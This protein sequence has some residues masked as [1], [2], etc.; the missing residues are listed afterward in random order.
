VSKRFSLSMLALTIGLAG[1]GSII[2]HPEQAV[3]ER[4]KMA[5][6]LSD[7]GLGDQSFSD[8]AMSGMS[9][10]REKEDWFI[11]Y[12][13]L[14]E[15]KSYETAFATLAK[16]HPTVVVGLGFMGQADL[17]KV[18]KQYPKQ[19]FA[20]IDAVSELPNV[21]SVTFKEDEG[22]YLAGAAA[23]IQSNNETIGFI[24]GMKSPLIE[25]FEKGYR[26]GATAINPDIR[27][28]VD[29]A[30][31]FA[32]PDKGR[33]LANAQ[34]KKEADVLYAAAGLTGSGV[35]EA[36]E[37]QGNKAIGVDS[38]QTAI[39][40]DAVMT[41]MLKQ[42]DLAITKIGDSVKAPGLQAGQIVLGVKDGAIQLAPIRNADFSAKD[43]QRLEQL[44][45]DILEGKVKVQ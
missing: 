11:D 6:V 30:E 37:E 9:L 10:L 40:P 8:A 41:S 16:Q 35:L 27:V 4:R 14:S 34:M 18:A 22:S 44:K 12:R 28:L 36:A 43:L 42:V 25:K 21:L 15:T 13:E 24:G 39:A 17:E 23:A 2:D 7:V 33:N 26:A 1:C 5:V 32:A 20:L 29:Y 45:Q 38:D 3:K 31:D 19:Q